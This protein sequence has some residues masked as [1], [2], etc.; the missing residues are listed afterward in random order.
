MMTATRT[1]SRLSRSL[2]AGAAAALLALFA[3]SCQRDGAGGAS[4]A[5]DG[6]GAKAAVPALSSFKTG[7]FAELDT[8][9]DLM[10]PAS[11]VLDADG[12]EKTLEQYKGKVVVLNIWAEWCG[13][14]V[15][16][17]PTLAKLQKEFEG[18][19]VVVAPVA[20]GYENA[21]DSAKAKL[22]ELSG[23]ELPFF[24]DSKYNVSAD[25]HSGAFPSTIIYGKDGKEAA[26]LML[27]ADWSSPEAKNL[28]QAVLDGAS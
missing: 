23:G 12:K 2:A 27:P 10:L 25:A 6:S 26:R 11:T 18:K 24:Y 4:A 20:F 16:E 8:D 28:V 5:S 19:D 14:C 17:M 13:P 9:Q 3:A 1:S 21:F 7:E 15:E 22:N